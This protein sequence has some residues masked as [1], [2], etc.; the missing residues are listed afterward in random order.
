MNKPLNPLRKEV[1]KNV[2]GNDY[3]IGDLHGCYDMFLQLL[4]V[5]KFNPDKDRMFSVGDLI[6]R[7]P[8]SLDCLRLTSED[9]FHSVFANHEEMMLHAF[10]KGESWYDSF[11]AQNW[12]HAGGVWGLQAQ[13]AHN[14]GFM[15]DNEHYEIAHYAKKLRELPYLLNVPVGDT[16]VHLVHAELPACS[17]IW[18]LSDDDLRDDTCVKMLYEIGAMGA[19]FGESNDMIWGRR[20]FQPFFNLD[21]ARTPKDVLQSMLDKHIK[22]RNTTP[23]TKSL[24]ISGHTPVSVPMMVDNHL[25]IDTGASFSQEEPI[26]GLTCYNMHTKKFVTVHSDRVSKN[27]EPVKLKKNV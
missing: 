18:E 3:V 1:E 27:V 13:I 4:E 17:N 26:Y 23:K 20:T 11:V 21:I 8:K 9:W 10:G 2:R 15:Y 5:I 14:K 7:G 12:E 25:N 22:G 16:W 19:G 6:D 24:V